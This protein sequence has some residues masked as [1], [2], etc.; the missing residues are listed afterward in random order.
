MDNIFLDTD[1]CLDILTRRKPH[2]QQSIELLRLRESTQKVRLCISESCIP[3]LIYFTTYKYKVEDS[4]I[5]LLDWIE[6]CNLFSI[7]AKQSIIEALNSDFSDKEDAIQYHTAIKG[8]ADYFITRNKKDY[9]PYVSAI[10]VY[11]PSEF[12]ELYAK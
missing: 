8:K 3:N 12:L 5:R 11:T 10:P 6:T 9:D 7:E 2:Y 4:N 1:V